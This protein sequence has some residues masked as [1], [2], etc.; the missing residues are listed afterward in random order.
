MDARTPERA[1][2]AL[3]AVVGA[4]IALRLLVG[5]A[6]AT[7]LAAGIVGGLWRAGA[8]VV[9]GSW[10]AQAV[11]FHAALMIGVFFGSVIGLERAVAVKRR[12][13]FTAPLAAALAGPCL[14]AGRVTAG[15]A[16]L[17]VA[18]IAFVAVNVAI[19][20]RQRQAH[21]VL[22]LVAALAWLAGNLG[23][24]AGEAGPATLSC[25]FAFLA[26]T[27]AAER[28]EITR[29]LRRRP[30][31]LATFFA[32]VAALLAGAA[33]SAVAPAA[34]GMGFGAA[35]SFW[36]MRHDIARRTVHAQGLSRY[37]AVCL[38]AGY[39]WLAVA[40]LAWVA[41][42]AGAFAARDAALHGLGI[43]F[44]LSMVM[45]HAPVILP[46]LARVKV[47]FGPW[48]YAPLALLHGSLLLRLAGGAVDPAWRARCRGQ[49][50]GLAADR[51]GH[52]GRCARL[53]PAALRRPAA[54]A[55]GCGK[56]RRAAISSPMRRSA[57]ALP[58]AC[59]SG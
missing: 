43:G 54:S 34:G 37:M 36:L 13:A 3:P 28:L 11:P 14:L 50:L 59:T 1:R 20:R 51:R 45:G 2:A 4:A 38:L 9:A 26:L 44:V 23:F 7:S 18:G 52:G 31:A 24:A 17:V 47:E 29:L 49:C 33:L 15:Q 5:A 55:Q 42:A 19:V 10:L 57:S 12:L 16:L 39:A 8:P 21:T 41:L 35:L 32:I 46:A 58:W 56:P 48:F 30:G 27:I 53:A 40:G 6:V 22:L 25:W